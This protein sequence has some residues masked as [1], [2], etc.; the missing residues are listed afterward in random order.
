MGAQESILKA[1]IATIVSK[2][3]RAT[4][5]GIFNSVFGLAWFIGSTIIG[6]I[7]EYSISLLV[8]FSLVSE[9][10]S[11]IFLFV[12]YKFRQKKKSIDENA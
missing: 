5:Y 11:I 12:F 3:K 2:E 9:I 6:A 1:V 7:Y 10:L 4:A 8:V